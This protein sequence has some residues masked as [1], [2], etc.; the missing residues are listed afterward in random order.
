MFPGVQFQLKVNGVAKDLTGS[1][2][3]LTLDGKIA[4]STSNGGLVFSDMVNGKVQ[5]PR[6]IINLNP[7]S[8]RI[9][10]VFMFPDGEMKTYLEGTWNILNR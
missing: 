1:V 3:N 10:L 7:K 5:F 2:V 8:Y 9:G 4:Y 6:Q